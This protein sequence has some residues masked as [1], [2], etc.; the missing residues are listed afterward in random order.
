M[1]RPFTINF[2]SSSCMKVL[3]GYWC[4]AIVI[5]KIKKELHKSQ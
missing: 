5:C 1:V 3:V 2:A 4:F